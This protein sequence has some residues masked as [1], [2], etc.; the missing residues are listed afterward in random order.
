MGDRRAKW[1]T[2]APAGGAHTQRYASEGAWITSKHCIKRYNRLDMRMF[3][4]QAALTKELR[5][6]IGDLGLLSYVGRDNMQMMDVGQYQHNCIKLYDTLD[7]R[8]FY[9]LLGPTF[10]WIME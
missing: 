3:Y 9:H 7:I 4:H 6:H 1:A 10:D 2:G 5:R 8:L